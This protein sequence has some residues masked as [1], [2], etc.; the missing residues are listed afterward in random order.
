MRLNC[1]RLLLEDHGRDA[2]LIFDWE[3]S[4]REWVSARKGAFPT[5]PNS[6]RA[7]G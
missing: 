2:A 6:A 3:R 4:T 1:V 7:L 5:K